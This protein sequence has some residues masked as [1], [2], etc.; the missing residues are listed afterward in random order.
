MKKE[1]LV[2]GKILKKLAPSIGASVYLEPK[3]NITGKITFKNGK[4]SYFR[5]NTLDLNP[6]GSTEIAKDKDYANHFMKKLGYPI[7][8]SSKT[9]FANPLA[10]D[11]KQK[12]Y[13]SE[14][15]LAYAKKLGWPVIIKPNSGSQGKGVALV[16]NEN[17]LKQGLKEIFKI[18]KIAL[19]QKYIAGNDYRLV[20]LDNEVISA[21]Q[22]QALS[23][24]GDGK[25]NI[26]QLLS[27]KQKEFIQQKR[28][29]KIKINDWRLINKLKRQNLTLKSIPRKGEEVYL[30][31][32]A[33]LSTGGK[34]IDVS[35]TIHSSYKKMAIKLTKDMGLRFCGVDILTN[36]DVNKKINKYW[37]IEINAAPGLDHYFKTG[38]KQAK[39]VEKLY[40]KILKNLEKNKLNS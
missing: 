39:L 35:Q 2:M 3:W 4:C 15:A 6:V 36:N 30:L 23:I 33:N 32:N 1:S 40:L 27:E 21:Y 28:D 11:I 38:K 14:A 17:E 8:P 37:I 9:F 34:A 16:Y 12:K 22:R 29:S 18:D 20:V 7:I 19:L 10:K 24:L 5:Y 13:N 26:F 31:D 25:S